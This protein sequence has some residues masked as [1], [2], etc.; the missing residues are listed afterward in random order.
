MA[1]NAQ[2]I[3]EEIL[4]SYPNL[5]ATYYDLH[6]HPELSFREWQTAERI[7]ARLRSEG[8][9]PQPIAGSGLLVRI[10]GK[11]EGADPRKAV[12]LR[13]DIDALPISEAT[14]LPYASTNKGVMHACG[15]DLHA[16]VLLGTLSFLARNSHLLG[17]TLFGLFQPGE[18]LNPGGAKLVL[19][20]NPFEGY[21]VV[22][23]VGCHTEPTLPTGTIGIKSGQYMAACDELHFT[24][25]GRG[26]HAA[27][28]QNII[29]PILPTAELIEALYAIPASAPAN[30]GGS[31]ISIGKIEAA[32]ATNVVP[33]EVR[34]EGTMRTF[35][36]GW[37]EEIKE[38]IEMICNHLEVQ[39]GITIERNF[40]CGYPSLYNSPLLAEESA[41]LLSEVFEVVPLDLRPTGEDFGYYTERY[42][43]LF[44]RLGV[45]YTGE[46]FA[47]H[48]AG[49]LHT[50]TFAPDTKA[51]GIGVVAMTMLALHFGAKRQK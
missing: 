7:A 17:C 48:K 45:G 16:T 4:G 31:I 42:P 41:K 25:K 46:E 43:S 18:E 27:L 40:G 9:E 10:D 50:P 5:I 14:S 12:V 39:H 24:L 6:A 22:A 35:D 30:V 11:A 21:E 33:D 32:G 44:Y 49:S 15:H 1:V 3:M 29:D 37:R 23:F 36:E 26:G 8:I 51:I 38:R 47:A 2:E 19:E 20:E 28:R 34:L 13:A